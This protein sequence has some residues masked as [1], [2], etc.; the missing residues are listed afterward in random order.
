MRIGDRE[1]GADQEPFII[2]E[3]GLNHCGSVERAM[4]M[5]SVAKEAGCDAVKYQTYK[6]EEFCQPDDP[7]FDTFKECELKREDWFELKAYC[8]YEKIIFMSTPQNPSDL[9]LLME[10]GIPAIKIGSDD[11][12]NLELI[13]NYSR[14]GLPL[15]LSCGMA[16]PEEIIDG[17][18]MLIHIDHVLMICTSQ[19]PCPPEEINILRIAHDCLPDTVVG[20]SDHTQGYIA[21]VAAVALGAC[22]FEKHF[23]TWEGVGAETFA[24]NPD[25]L[26]DWVRAIR[27]AH[28]ML[29]DGSFELSERELESRKK[30]QRKAGNQLRGE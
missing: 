22:V 21:A 15:L 3:A 5:A 2:G 8:D 1:I 14:R 24:E 17:L 10:V 30:W 20:F 12:A 25:G 27:A 19:Y 11:F 16:T 23:K 13:G 29:G 28:V 9:D 26:K 18:S 6:T 4:I 7:M